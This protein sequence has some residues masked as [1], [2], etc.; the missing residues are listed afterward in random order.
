MPANGRDPGSVL[1]LE[2]SE[3][4]DRRMPSEVVGVV[5]QDG[6]RLPVAQGLLDLGSER[7]VSVPDP[8]LPEPPAPW[9][10]VQVALKLAVAMEVREWIRD[11]LQASRKYHPRAE[12][13]EAGADVAHRQHDE[14]ISVLH[15]APA[16]GDD[17][18]H[19]RRAGGT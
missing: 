3:V 8:A 19:D 13:G 15:Q 1:V 12:H 18:G 10:N 14:E 2:Q 5:E 6:H 4:T 16:L 7:V 9:R 11:L 17:L